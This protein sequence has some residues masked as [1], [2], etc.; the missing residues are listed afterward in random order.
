MTAEQEY[1]IRLSRAAIFDEEPPLPPEKLDWQYLWDK[2]R[3]QNLSGLLASKIIKLPKDKQPD[4][5][6]QWKL[7]MMRIAMTMGN[8]FD[9]FERMIDA[10]R[11]NGIEPICLK[12]VVVKDLY[13]EPL[14]RTMGDFDVW[15]EKEKLPAVRDFFMSEGYS[16]TEES[17]GIDAVKDSYI[18]EIFFTLEEEFR[19]NCLDWDKRFPENTVRV[20]SGILSLNP[21]Y[22]MSHMTLHLGKHMVREGSGIRSLLDIALYLRAYKDEIDFDFVRASCAEQH[23]ENAYVYI[24][25][26]VNRF[27]DADV[28]VETVDADRFVEYMLTGG[29]F[30]AMNDN[31]MIHQAAKHEDNVGFI[32]RMFFPTVKMLDYRYTY[33]KKYP[34]LLP[35]AWVHRVIYARTHYGY[36]LKQMLKG[37]RGSAEFAKERDKWLEELELYDKGD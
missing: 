25:N 10:S 8:R 31:V 13:P 12:G 20:D 7:S 17:M 32:R 37:F 24:M 27:F 22:M 18:W 1:F 9:E 29:V 28:E 36:S 3:E 19:I 5:A 30:G 11:D 16:I 15:I 4:N 35:V 21:T 33:L 2:S 23:F 26:A 34:F 6:G 14:L